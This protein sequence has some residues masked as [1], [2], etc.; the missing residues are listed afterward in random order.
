MAP[1][2]RT[3]TIDLEDLEPESRPPPAPIRSSPIRA[4]LSRW[5]ASVVLAACLAILFLAGRRAWQRRAKGPELSGPSATVTAPV[6]NPDPPP[7]EPAANGTKVAT[8]AA[9]PNAPTAAPTVAAGARRAPASPKTAGN[10]APAP[11]KKG[12]AVHSH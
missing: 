4:A 5:F 1:T 12:G 10:R 6:S 3:E 2:T 8:E 9:P 11:R 7:I